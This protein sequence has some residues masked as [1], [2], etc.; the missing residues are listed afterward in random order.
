MKKVIGIISLLLSVTLATANPI[1]FDK[2]FKESAKIEKQIKRTSF[3]KRTYLITDF[4][5]KPDTPD[6]PCHEAIN[7]A[8]LTCS[9]NGG[10]TVVV[11]KGTFHT[12]PITLKS[13]VNFHVEEGAVLKFS[14]D[15]S[16][17]FPA[18]ITRWE[19]L[20]CY[21]ARPLIYAYG[22]T[23][24]AITGKGTID[25]QGSNETWWP[26]CG[27]PRYGWKEG[28]VAQRNGGRE[29]LLMYG[30]TSTPVYKRIMKPEDGMRPQLINLYSCNTVLIED[31]TLLNSPFWVIHPL[32]CE[33]LI[34]RGVHVFNRGPNGDGC[35]PESCK[36][37]LIEN[38]TFDTGD[39]C[40]AI[41]SGRNQDGRKWN[42]PSEN[43]IVRGCFMKN[44]HGGVVIGSE[45]SGGYRNLFVENCRMD[46]PDLNRVIRIKTSTCRGGLIENVFVRNVTVGQCREAVLRI[47]LQY[48]NREKCNRGY[49]PTVRNV[50]LKNVTCEKS[51][52]G[53]LITGLDDDKHVYN[54]SVE[55]SR[56]NNVKEGKNRISGAKDVTFKNLYINGELVK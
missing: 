21:N 35:D 44:G 56:F 6:E 40:I 38:C 12:G 48:E 14:T 15:Q 20:D 22:E 55:D 31:V 34:V 51:K 36:N 5:A 11:P 43:I 29:R 47:N 39:D 10:G 37:V 2:A 52:L 53:V 27:A 17:Y 28:M 7:R 23:N 46:S 41:K 50:H 16:L 32:F 30:E 24:I 26:M 9:L 33:S 18:V 8:I 45:I 1:D 42:I 3:P 4:G 19:G 54:V 49:A 13:N 25:G